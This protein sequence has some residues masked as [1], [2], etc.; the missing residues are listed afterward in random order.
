MTEYAKQWLLNS[1][2]NCLNGLISTDIDFHR[3]PPHSCTVVCGRRGQHQSNSSWFVINAWRI[4]QS[5][6]NPE[7]SLL[8]RG[9]SVLAEPNSL[10]VGNTPSTYLAQPTHTYK[11]A[12][13][14][15]KDGLDMCIQATSQSVGIVFIFPPT[16]STVSSETEIRFLDGKT[17]LFWRL[18]VIR[19]CI[20]CTQQLK[21]WSWDPNTD[22]RWHS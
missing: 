21:W 5:V 13:L 17:W 6:H 10:S 18:D 4:T 20:I 12:G 15:R 2:K 1:L 19:L 16:H 7:K 22:S 14:E 3:F 9:S 8:F 11:R